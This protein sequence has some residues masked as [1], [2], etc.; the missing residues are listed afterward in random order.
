MSI[1]SPGTVIMPV[2]GVHAGIM[3][4][5]LLLA[6]VRPAV[7][8]NPPAEELRT[9]AQV[10]SLTPQQAGQHLPVRLKG[11]VT[12]SDAT[13]FSHFIQDETAGIYLLD[14]NLPA[15][16]PGQLVE[17][18]G[19]SSP[20]EY[21]PIIVP[22]SVKVVGEGTLPAAKPVSAEQLVSGQEDSQFVE[23][24]G[25]VRSVKFEE[26]TKQYLIDLVMSGERFTAYASQ[27]PVTN[28]EVLVD[29]IVKASGVCSTLFNRQRQLFGFRLLMPRAEDLAVEKPALASPFDIPTQSINSL[30]Q[31]TPQGTFGHRVKLNGTVAYYESGSAVFIQDEN[32]GVYCQTRQR[33]PV[34]AG[35]RV[36]VL[37]FPAKGEY[38]PVLQDA[39]YRKIGDGAAPVPATL[40][41][42]EILTGTYDCRLIQISARLLERTQ[43]GR[44]QFLVLEKNGFIFDAYLGQDA[45]GTG[46]APLQN[47]S[48]VL[49]TGICLIERGSS[50][51]AGQGWRAKSFRLLLR[52]LGDVVV[53]KTPPVWMQWDILHIVGFLVVIIL[54]ALLWILILHRR[55]A[56]HHAPKT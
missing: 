37:G 26:E 45:S 15:L 2:T 32:E 7:A 34:Q 13:L 51:R 48:D 11:V 50:W 22:S 9:A 20:G 38:T 6:S 12:F 17:V 33:T 18:E 14:T 31:F 49:V 46:F 35:D 21:A 52:S 8:Q 10:R 28:T 54:A 56:A 44:E 4:L 42:D 29:S 3:V 27:L 19:Y 40:D 24:S 16:S 41:L 30:L 5:F 39:I 25:I 23:V 1:R 43:R 53:Q 55:I 36:E 47:G